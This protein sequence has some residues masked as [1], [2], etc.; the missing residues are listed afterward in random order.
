[1]VRENSNFQLFK[2]NV[3]SLKTSEGFICYKPS[4]QMITTSTTKLFFT[5]P[6][7]TTSESSTAVTTTSTA[8]ATTSTVVATTSTAVATTSTAD[9]TTSTAELNITSQTSAEM[10]ATNEILAILENL[11]SEFDMT[12]SSQFSPQSFINDTKMDEPNQE[13]LLLSEDKKSDKVSMIVGIT[14]A[15]IVVGLATF[16]GLGTL[17][18]RLL[19]K[20]QPRGQTVTF[21][22]EDG[23][24]AEIDSEKWQNIVSL[25]KSMD[26]V[27]GEI[28][29]S[30]MALSQSST[31][32]RPKSTDKSIF[33]PN[34]KS[35]PYAKPN[36]KS[37]SFKRAQKET[38]QKSIGDNY[39]VPIKRYRTKDKDE[40]G[41][42]TSLFEEIKEAEDRIHG[43]D[44]KNLVVD[45]SE[46]AGGTYN[47]ITSSFH[48]LNK[49]PKSFPH[50]DGVYQAT[51]EPVYDCVY[52]SD[53]EE[54]NTVA[55]KPVETKPGAITACGSCKKCA[56]LHRK[57]V[58]KSMPSLHEFESNYK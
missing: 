41:V 45:Y 23:P 50:E 18:Y 10:T 37:K 42:G 17:I 29:K 53:S 27:E 56:K 36:K 34:Y 15:A 21:Y 35:T 30:M 14:L 4:T 40:V 48:Y 49:I 28:R 3:I 39:K 55:N 16:V 9:A 25:C 22:Y 52:N 47:Y 33:D 11:T 5:T 12:T 20:R 44:Q 43:S 46:L 38:D 8:D 7:T 31:I 32:S 54:A 57:S 58:A 1:M 13:I 19:I 2:T 24:Y 6:I 51:T 26:E